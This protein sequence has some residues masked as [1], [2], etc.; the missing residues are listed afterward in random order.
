MRS[1][2]LLFITFLLAFD[3]YSQVPRNIVVEH[4][5]NTRCPICA[6]RNPG[7]FTN[8]DDFPDAIHLAIHPSS[9]YSNCVLNQHN[10]VEN[11]ARTNFYGIYGGTPR[12]VIQGKVIPVSANY[13]DSDLFASESGMESNY[14][15]DIVQTLN[16]AQD[17][18]T[19]EVHIIRAAN[20]TMDSAWLYAALAE[21]ELDYAAPNGEDKHYDV[22][23]ESL[24]G[25]AGMAVALPAVID[26]ETLFTATVVV[27]SEWELTELFALAVLQDPM[28][29]E[30]LQAKSAE[31][32]PWNVIASIGS[33]VSATSVQVF[34]N[35][36]KDE[37]R[38]QGLSNSATLQVFDLLGQSIASYS[39]ATSLLDTSLLPS[40]AYVLAVSDNGA[41]STFRLIKP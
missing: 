9:P 33:A 24:F 20:D 37:I 19:V 36:F 34:P 6:N 23:R 22:F 5:T 27:N 1:A 30:V 41:Q 29:N 3:M 21:S 8:L 16:A 31:N 38:I 39:G 12:L 2:F 32:E 4:F 18:V 35:P 10:T 17:S 26:D 15:I 25:S 13:G 14:S 11:D 7:F 40:G 28:N